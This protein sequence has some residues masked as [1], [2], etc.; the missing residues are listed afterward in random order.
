MSYLALAK[1]AEEELKG[2]AQDDPILDPEQW[3]PHFRDLHYKVIAETPHFDYGWI[4]Q[5][6]L[7]LYRLIKVKENEI[8]S[9]GAAKLSQV[10]EL[11]R[12]WR[13]LVLTACFDQRAELRKQ[14]DRTK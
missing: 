8:D 3:Y 12:E 1:K 11:L 4:R 7:E 13:E 10:M 5:N 2:S 14:D 6:R 9:L